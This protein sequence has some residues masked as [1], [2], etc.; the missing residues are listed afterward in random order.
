[1]NKIQKM[2]MSFAAVAMIVSFSAFKSG[3]KKL[4]PGQ[5]RF[6][7]ISG[8]A[9]STNPANFVYQDNSTLQCTVAPEL[10]CTAVWTVDLPGTD[11]A[12]S[13]GDRPIDFTSRTYDGDVTTGDSN[14]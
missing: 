14:E 2:I 3:E 7:N 11:T 13:P 12:P 10:E 8:V 6:Y 5:F 9:N 1:M 4:A